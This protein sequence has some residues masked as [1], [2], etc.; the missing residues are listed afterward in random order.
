MKEIIK[1][2]VNLIESTSHALNYYFGYKLSALHCQLLTKS[3]QR[4]YILVCTGAQGNLTSVWK[5]F[6]VISRAQGMS[7]GA[8]ARPSGDNGDGGTRRRGGR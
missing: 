1:E 8:L 4:K 6:T 5:I 2:M 7:T 3:E